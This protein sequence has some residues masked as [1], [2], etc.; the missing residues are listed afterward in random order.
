[1]CTI[2]RSTLL[3]EQKNGHTHNN[4]KIATT[5]YDTDQRDRHMLTD[6]IIFVHILQVNISKVKNLR[7]A[8]AE[9]RSA[10]IFHLIPLPHHC[11][12]ACVC[13]C[14]IYR[15]RKKYCIFALFFS[16]VTWNDTCDRMRRDNWNNANTFALI[17]IGLS[18]CLRKLKIS[19]QRQPNTFCRN[20]IH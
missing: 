9:K 18:A 6:A 11:V 1:M 15:E 5:K 14:V 7:S 10:H 20:I 4:K 17:N 12:C 13:V 3:G 2:H 19:I 8:I 16:S